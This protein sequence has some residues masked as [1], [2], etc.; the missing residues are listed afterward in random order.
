MRL[1]DFSRRIEGRT[2]ADGQHKYHSGQNEWLVE[3]YLGTA[4]TPHSVD[5]SW[6][7]SW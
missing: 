2:A 6:H 3:M 5:P 1:Q 7:G 4:T